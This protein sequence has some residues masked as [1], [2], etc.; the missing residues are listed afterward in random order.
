MV[1]SVVKIA[2]MF[3]GDTLLSSFAIF[4]TSES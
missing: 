4:M 3:F 1:I 2:A